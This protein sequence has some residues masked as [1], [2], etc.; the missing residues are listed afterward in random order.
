MKRGDPVLL[1]TNVVIEAVRTKRWKAISGGLTLETVRECESEIDAGERDLLAHALARDDP[2]LWVLA[3]PD[4]AAI[5]T[6]VQAGVQDQLVSLAQVPTAV[7][8]TAD[9]RFHFT[10]SWLT[11][12]RTKALLGG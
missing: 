9:L 1:D 8:V 3:S 12:E 10:T 6:A 4:K 5:A 2:G 7:G 11:A